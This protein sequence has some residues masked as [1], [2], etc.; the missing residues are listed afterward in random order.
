MT[1]QELY[2]KAIE[3]NALDKDIIVSY[4]EWDYEDASFST[5]ETTINDVY[6]CRDQIILELN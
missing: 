6:T 2:R 5:R 4:D 3:L 1:I